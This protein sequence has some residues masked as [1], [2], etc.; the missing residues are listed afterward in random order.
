MSDLTTLVENAIIDDLLLDPYLSGFNI[1]PHD[2]TEHKDTSDSP[3]N[4]HQVVVVVTALD[5]GDFVGTYG[6]GIRNIKVEVEINVS[7][8][9]PDYGVVLGQIVE[10][11]SMRLQPSTTLAG[12]T[13]R[14]F[15]TN[16]LKVYGILDSQIKDERN[17]LDKDGTR[18]RIVE[19]TFVAA[20][21][22]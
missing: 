6:A 11:V 5:W 15:S 18:Q 9:E 22:G 7:V 19:R 20:K 13:N 17:D 14:D 16:D 1:V 2:E 3:G 8:S 10:K 12:V 21:I 4:A